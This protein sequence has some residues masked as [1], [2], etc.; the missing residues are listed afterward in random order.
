MIKRSQFLLFNGILIGFFGLLLYMT[1]KWPYVV[2]IDRYLI[3]GMLLSSILLLTKKRFF[4]KLTVAF[5]CVGVSY[6]TLN[7]ILVL[8]QFDMSLFCFTVMSMLMATYCMD[9]LLEQ[10]LR[11][12]FKVPKWDILLVDDDKTFRRVIAANF[13]KYGIEIRC[14]ENGEEGLRLAREATPDLIIL[15]VI[16]PGLKGREVCERLKEDSQTADV[17]VIFLTVQDSK[18]DV[19]AELAA[20]AVRHLSKPIQFKKLLQEVERILGV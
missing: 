10:A 4:L 14:A 20:G 6:G 5:G 3:I 15:D 11:W 16:M 8:K 9:P 18:D 13:A 2:T 1:V 7:F 17:P 12:K 19:N